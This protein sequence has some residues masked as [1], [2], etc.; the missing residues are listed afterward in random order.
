MGWTW[1]YRSKEAAFRAVVPTD[2]QTREDG[3]RIRVIDKH[4]AREGN[5]MKSEKRD[6]PFHK[7]SVLFGEERKLP[8]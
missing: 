2:D 6:V 7:D 1:P 8:D 4:G 5:Q 3:K